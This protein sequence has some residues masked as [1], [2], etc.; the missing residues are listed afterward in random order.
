MSE[1]PRPANL[2]LIVIDDDIGYCDAL[3]EIV[4]EDIGLS[5]EITH[6]LKTFKAK[7]KQAENQGSPFAIA[8]IDMNLAPENAISR[9]SGRQAIKYIKENHP[10]I[11]CIMTSGSLSADTVLQLRDEFGLDAYISKAHIE[12]ESLEKEIAK[13][14]QRV[15]S[16]KTG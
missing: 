14:L 3:Q 5:L 16:K 12:A 6:D 9:R 15:R 7:I 1:A 4:E 13:A 10:Y 2:K 11:G 8:V